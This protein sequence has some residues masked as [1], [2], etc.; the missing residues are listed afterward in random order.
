MLLY[1]TSLKMEMKYQQLYF[2]M[3]KLKEFQVPTVVHK[4]HTFSN[5]KISWKAKSCNLQAI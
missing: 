5:E 2:H 3:V 4:E 1:N